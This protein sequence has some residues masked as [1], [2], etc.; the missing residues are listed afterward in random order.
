[1]A[2]T[3]K[4]EYKGDKVKARNLIGLAKLQL[5]KL[6]NLM[7]FAGLKQYGISLHDKSGAYILAASVFGMEAVEVYV[8]PMSKIGKIK[9][10]IR[11]LIE[12]KIKWI[13]LYVPINLRSDV[14]DAEG[15]K[16]TLSVTGKYY[17]Q[18]KYTE[19][20]FEAITVNIGNAGVYSITDDL[21]ITL[22]DD[23]SKFVS[24]SYFTQCSWSTPDLEYIDYP[25]GGGTPPCYHWV[26][27][28]S[29]GTEGWFESHY[30]Y[31][32]L[33]N[34]D[35][36]STEPAVYWRRK[37]DSIATGSTEYRWYTW[38]TDPFDPDIRNQSPSALGLELTTTY[39]SWHLTYALP[40][41]EVYKEWD[42]T[43]SQMR[44]YGLTH[45]WYKDD[46]NYGFILRRSEET[47]HNSDTTYKIERRFYLKREGESED[48]LLSTATGWGS[49]IGSPAGS[50]A[51]LI[52]AKCYEKDEVLNADDVPEENDVI[53]ISYFLVN[54]IRTSYDILPSPDNVPRTAAVYMLWSDSG[55]ASS[56]FVTDE[57]GIWILKV[58]SGVTINTQGECLVGVLN[59]EDKRIH[60]IDI[61]SEEEVVNVN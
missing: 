47:S 14:G 40:Q 10:T 35:L 46:N 11:K 61:E 52:V 43:Y 18:S 23:L 39:D 24:T 59:D 25:G 33:G 30:G 27:T 38:S 50:M 2:R 44:N 57:D 16:T 51:S 26:S 8:P 12:E 36:W 28:L 42:W 49:D 6:R 7:S 31:F 54:P 37:S 19:P 22:L 58:F 45:S 48:V 32:I 21:R 3:T 15:R 41:D 13:P 17:K 53:L 1:L 55:F 29:G 56:S 34:G 5:E 4:F 60:Y 20:T 9:K